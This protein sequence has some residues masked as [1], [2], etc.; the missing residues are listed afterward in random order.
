MSRI[1]EALKKAEQERAAN[2]AD[3]KFEEPVKPR[4]S[5]QAV[6]IAIEDEMV[7]APS[8]L[9]DSQTPGDSKDPQPD[10]LLANCKKTVWNPDP[11]FMIVSS[12]HAF[13][14]RAEH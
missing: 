7:P 9:P 6:K 1:H 5:S 3:R 12:S 2:Q 13:P 10:E 8:V 4:G 11:N 14:V